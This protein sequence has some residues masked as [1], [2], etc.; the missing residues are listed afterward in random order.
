MCLP[1]QWR[2]QRI[3]AKQLR[4]C[5]GDKEHATRSK[6]CFLISEGLLGLRGGHVTVGDIIYVSLLTAGETEAWEGK[7]NDA[8]AEEH[9]A[10]SLRAA[11]FQT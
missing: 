11:L 4:G 2:K 9:R 1:E 10:D 5:G 7:M 6:P 8:E 3:E